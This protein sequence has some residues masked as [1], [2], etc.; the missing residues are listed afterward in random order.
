MVGSERPHRRR[1]HAAPRP[2]RPARLRDRP[3]RA[4][5]PAGHPALDRHRHAGRPQRSS[6]ATT[7]RS[8]CA[9]TGPDGAAGRAAPTS[10]LVVVDEAVLS[11]TGY[12][13]ADPLAVFYTDICVERAQPSTCARASSSTAPTWSPTA[14]WLRGSSTG[15]SDRRDGA[16]ERRPDRG[17]RGR[18][19]R[20]SAVPPID[21]RAELRRRSR[22]TRPTSPPT[23]T[24]P[25]T[26]DVPLPDSLTRYRVMAVAI[27]GA[28]HF[29]KGESTITARLPLQVRPSAPRFL[30]FGD[31]FELPVVVQNQTDRPI[32]VDVAVQAA[33]PRAHRR[34][35]VV[36]SR[37][38]PT[39]ASRSG[40]PPPPPRSA[41]RG[42]ASPPSA[43]CHA[44]A[45]EVELPGVHAGHRRGVRH[46]RRHRR[47]RRRASRRWRRPTCSRSSAGSR[48]TPRRRR[49]RR[50][51]TPCSTSTTTGTTR[52]TATPRASWRSPRCA[53]CSTRSTPRACPTPSE[54]DT[55][56]EQR[57]RS[58]GR[59]PERRRRVPVLA[60]GPRV[61][62]LAVDPI[63][64]RA[65]ARRRRRVSGA[66]RRIESGTRS[67][68]PH[69]GVLP[70][71]VRRRHPQHPQFVRAVRA[72]RGRQARRRQGD[73]P[74]RAGGQRSRTRRRSR[75]CGRRSPMPGSAPRSNAASPTA[76]SRRP[77]QQRSRP[78]MARTP[79]SSPTPTAGPM[80]SSSTR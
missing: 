11:L 26:V 20:R 47:R 55:Q 10:R 28:D 6:R 69:R 39:T 32:D 27:D 70:V 12:D 15:D 46:L 80:A 49:S 36:G 77:A 58:L 31:R 65:R 74:L 2:A 42:S 76:P 34:R 66:R 16:G 23:P 79:T 57:H 59:A 8:P 73:R 5:D 50:S 9:V 25:V 37:C 45:A 75:G 30:N 29:G 68:R 21:V 60:A 48:S 13:L 3:D 61:D 64:P 78:A 54:L 7:R 62:P 72:G 71:D 33:E 14:T 1:R 56:G 24:A 52:P 43:A 18:W 51:P 35:R 53:T 4:V 41:P 19:R 38:P 22:C 40:S 63:D 17:G 44:D 67:P